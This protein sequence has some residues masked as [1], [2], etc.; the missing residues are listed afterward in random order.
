MWDWPFVAREREL[1]QIDSAF[2]GG[3]LGGLV[4]AGTAGAGKSRLARVALDRLTARGHRVESFA[5]TR[6][7]ASIPY[8][9]LAPLLPEHWVASGSGVGALRALG[10]QVAEW[11]GRAQV[12]IAV[13]D[14][15]Q[16]DE[17]SAAALSHLATHRLAFVLAT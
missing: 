8:G 14:A 10:R 2:D 15:H 4:I 11:G 13:D 3:T 17:A 1:G 12:V 9:C 5:A 6:A 16:L 7:I